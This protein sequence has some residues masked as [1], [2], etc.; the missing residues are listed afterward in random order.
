MVTRLAFILGGSAV[1]AAIWW[2]TLPGDTTFAKP[3]VG[4]WVARWLR[5]LV[6]R[7]V[8]WVMSWPHLFERFVPGDAP[9]PM[10]STVVWRDGCVELRRYSQ[11]PGPVVLIVHAFVS[12]A[13]I[14]D[15]TPRRS[16]VR[17][18]SEQGFDVFLLDWGRAGRAESGDGLDQ[19]AARLLEAERQAL[20][21]AGAQELHLLGY[22]A[23]GMLSLMRL[24]SHPAEHV[25]TFTGLAPPVDMAV[26]VTGGMGVVLSAKSLKPVLALDQRGCVP[27]QL[28]RE[29]FHI[30]RPKVLASM[31]DLIRNRNNP[32]FVR[33]FKALS[34]WTWN[35]PPI[36]GA[37]F[38]DLVELYRS[39]AL[40]Q[41]TWELLGKRVDLRNV[42]TPT[43]LAVSARDHIVPVGS[44]LALQ[45]STSGRLE[46]MIC[47]TGHV[48]MIT[49][50][51][52]RATL[53]PRIVEWLREGSPGKQKESRSAA[54]T[55]RTRRRG[56]GDDQPRRSRAAGTK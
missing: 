49:G 39:N 45:G 13:A 40:F 24:A 35:Q 54:K 46:T 6:V 26:P 7:P 33:E 1:V 30:L 18:L 16:L 29:S 23:G 17:H 52:G 43:L 20:A 41:G 2:F 48:S 51:T 42:I 14:L 50:D 25:R 44:S 4:S 56:T 55:G 34:R 22:C 38:F 9:E 47:Q 27:G 5:W 32:L 19:Y 21:I 28:I 11:G 3:S 31:R 53:W 8:L 15:L 36:P 37:L 12:G 10:P